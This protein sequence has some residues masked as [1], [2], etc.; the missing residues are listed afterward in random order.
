MQFHN[1][2]TNMR[3]QTARKSLVL[4]VRADH[5]MYP[6]LFAHVHGWR[7]SSGQFAM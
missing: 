2:R 3:K 1:R 5:S 4:P 7:G 6:L